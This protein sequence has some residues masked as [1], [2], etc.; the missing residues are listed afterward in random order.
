MYAF[1]TLVEQLFDLNSSVIS[2]FF[3][4]LYGLT[5]LR[6]G[7]DLVALQRTKSVVQSFKKP[8][9]NRFK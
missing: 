4:Y 8:G 3:V 6:S 2:K 5:L 9:T 1:I 7:R